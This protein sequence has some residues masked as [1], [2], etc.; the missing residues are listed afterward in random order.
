MKHCVD[1]LNMYS[2]CFLKKLGP[3][4]ML[5]L[6]HFTPHPQFNVVLIKTFSWT[7]LFSINYDFASTV[8][9]LCPRS[10]RCVVNASS[11]YIH[12]YSVFLVFCL[13]YPQSLYLYNCFHKNC[14]ITIYFV[15]CFHVHCFV[16]CRWW[17]NKL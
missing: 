11:G 15:H 12:V 4:F 2:G 16:E 7:V 1:I 8:L 14:V 5:I 13:Q 3:C 6:S 17:K 10:P 9:S